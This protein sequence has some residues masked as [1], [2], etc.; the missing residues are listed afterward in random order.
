M[1]PFR[2]AAARVLG[3]L[4]LVTG[5]ALPVAMSSA[6]PEPGGLQAVAEQLARDL[7]APGVA[8]QIV[9]PGDETATAVTGVDGRGA[10]IRA[11]TPFVWGS[12]S[13]SVTGAVTEALV[14]RGD[15]SLDSVVQQVV[16]QSRRL[17]GET[18]VTVGDLLHHTSGLPHDVSLT[19]DWSR[20]GGALDAI[21]PM[22]RPA[23]AVAPGSFRYS[24]LNYLVLQAVIEAV[25]GVPYAQTLR[26]TVLGPAGA[27]GVLTTPDEYAR[28]VPPGHVPFF[29]APRT[30]DVGVDEAGLGY[31]Y[32]AGSVN[33]LGAYVR[34]RMRG[35]ERQAPATAAANAGK[36]YGSGLFREEFGGSAVWWHSGAVP[37]YYTFIGMVPGSDRA[38]VAVVNRYGEL[39]SIP[40]AQAGRGL[41]VNV[42]NDPQPQW[43]PTAGR[44]AE[45]P[46]LSVLIVLVVV[47][48]VVVALTSVRLA[49]GP[50][51]RGIRATAARV[52]AITM[53]GAALLAGCLIGVPQVVGVSLPV[54]SLWA[55]DVALLFWVGVGEI[56]LVAALSIAAEA[57]GCIRA[58]RISDGASRRAEECERVRR[59]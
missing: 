3:V 35:I 48:I 21:G 56:F 32:L 47:L 54:I 1:Y 58:C 55:P 16:P 36:Q 7:D 50:R 52:V 25:T 49:R 30:V 39:E 18:P 17:V 40:I 2:G 12:V 11:D 13:K 45:G 28:S 33:D 31:G 29:T 57:L 43:F 53:V 10:P 38:I 5:L 19:D 41:L 26:D 37:G 46:V 8:V 34:W 27:T 59:P 6:A 24:S 51:A 15:L 44:G 20:R 23:G 42:L 9:G 14:A 4:L 22:Q